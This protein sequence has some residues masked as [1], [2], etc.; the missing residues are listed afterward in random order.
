M[1][2]EIA[3]LKILSPNTIAYK[4]TSAFSIL[5]IARTDTGSVAEIKDPNA[6]ASEGENVYV[7]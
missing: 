3:S 2:I 4:F 5:K 7:K 1:T 6:I